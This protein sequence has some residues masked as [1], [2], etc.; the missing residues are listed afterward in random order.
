MS[1]IRTPAAGSSLVP[2]ARPAPARVETVR[3]AQRAFFEAALTGAAPSVPGAQ[4]VTVPF[5]TRPVPTTPHGFLRPGSLVDIK[6]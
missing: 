4:A 1:D 6:V 2:N 5:A 3:A